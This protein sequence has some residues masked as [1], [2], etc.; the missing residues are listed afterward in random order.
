MK[1]SK[2]NEEIT[3]CGINNTSRKVVTSS[4]VTQ[5]K[6]QHGVVLQLMSNNGT[7]VQTD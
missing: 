6:S 2:G 4:P 5:T 3:L 7:N 1:F